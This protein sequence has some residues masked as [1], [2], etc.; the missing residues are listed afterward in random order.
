MDLKESSLL[1]QNFSAIFSWARYEN[2]EIC[3][4][5]RKCGFVDVYMVQVVTL[6][7]VPWPVTSSSSDTVSA[8]QPHGQWYVA[9]HGNVVSFS[10]LLR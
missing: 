5:C 4:M 9:M 3:K 8:V 7:L 10:G 2:Y 1:M 6:S